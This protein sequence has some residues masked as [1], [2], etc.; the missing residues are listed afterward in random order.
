[1]SYWCSNA[2][3]W[4]SVLIKQDSGVS[5]ILFDDKNTESCQ[6]LDIISLVLTQNAEFVDLAGVLG[7]DPNELWRWRCSAHTVWLKPPELRCSNNSNPSIFSRPWIKEKYFLAKWS[8]TQ[9]LVNSWENINKTSAPTHPK[10][11]HISANT[12]PIYWHM[13]AFSAQVTLGN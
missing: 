2:M 4:A 10:T 1:M 12:L 11:N 8:R 13:E 6:G 9:S 7:W 3:I 5:L